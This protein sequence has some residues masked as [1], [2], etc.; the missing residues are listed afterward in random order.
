M[1][2]TS[3]RLRQRL[4]DRERAL[5]RR[6]RRARSERDAFGLLCAGVGVLFALAPF[7]EAPRMPHELRALALTMNVAA[8]SC[9]AAWFLSNVVVLPLRLAALRRALARSR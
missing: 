9:L 1:G 4:Q 8:A 5:A 7:W 2:T 6:L 3:E